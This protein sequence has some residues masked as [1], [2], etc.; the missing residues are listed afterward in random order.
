MTGMPPM[1]QSPNSKPKVG[2]AASRRNNLFSRIR[3]SVATERTTATSTEAHEESS[4]GR[5]TITDSVDSPATKANPSPRNKYRNRILPRIISSPR[6]APSTL[7][8]SLCFQL[9]AN[10]LILGVFV[11]AYSKSL[12]VFPSQRGMAF[13]D[14][15]DMPKGGVH[16]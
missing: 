11:K 4:E 12:D 2:F 16:S 13:F 7:R 14:M 10:N 6:L 5:K 15:L 3:N 8:V 9:L 1:G